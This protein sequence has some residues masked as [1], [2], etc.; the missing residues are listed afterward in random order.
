VDP[1]A[2]MAMLM[3]GG[4]APPSPD[5]G[6]MPDPSMAQGPPPPDM[7]GPPPPQFQSTNPD[8]IQHILGMLTGARA[9]DHAQLAQ[10]QDSVLASIMAAMGI[11]GV[12]PQSGF[13]EGATAPQM[14]PEQMMGGGTG[15]SMMAPPAPPAPAGY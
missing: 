5:P 3:G 2:L 13:A 15:P 14:G 8:F 4:G 9:Q 7:Q 11:G 1:Q 10:Q 6:M 12:D